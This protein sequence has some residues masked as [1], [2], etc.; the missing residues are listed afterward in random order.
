MNFEK[1]LVQVGKSENTAK[2]YSQAIEKSISK[3]AWEAG[4]TDTNLVHLKSPAQLGELMDAIKKLE[5][6]QERNSRGNG[7][8]SAALV[9]FYQYLADIGSNELEVDLDKILADN[10]VTAT[11]KTA[12][13]SIRIGQG[14]F[15]EELI[16]HWGG[17]AVSGYPN[18]RFLVASH[19]KP[20]SKSSNSERVD[21]FNGILLLPNL[22]KVFDLGYVTFDESGVIRISQAIEQPELLGLRHNLKVKLEEDHQEYMAYHRIQ[23]F[24][25]LQ[26]LLMLD[27]S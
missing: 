16:S 11:E 14:K 10:T 18:C 15:R 22:D 24:E 23:K 13:I 1:W 8:Y 5:I 7:M 9:Q 2:K 3:W 25:Q 27:G 26:K 20:W 6:F 12:Q 19:I 21:P 17:C 4:L